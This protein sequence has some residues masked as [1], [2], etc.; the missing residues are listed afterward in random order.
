[1]LHLLCF[2]LHDSAKNAATKGHG[3]HTLQPSAGLSW[4]CELLWALVEMTMHVALPEI[5]TR[6]TLDRGSQDDPKMA[7]RVQG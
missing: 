1:M 5:H 3:I 4:A 7:P 2:W 6:A